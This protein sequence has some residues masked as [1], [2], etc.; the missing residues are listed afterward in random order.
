MIKR[1]TIICSIIGLALLVLSILGMSSL[2]MHAKSLQSER[3]QEFFSVAKKVRFDVKKKLDDFLLTEQTRPYTDYQ[4]YYVP[5]TANRANALVRSPLADKFSNGLANGYFQLNSNNNI[6]NPYAQSINQAAPEVKDYLTNLSKNLLPSLGYGSGLQ[7]SRVEPNN[8][9]LD[10]NNSLVDS[11][12][13]AR[14]TSRSGYQ[15]STKQSESKNASNRSKRYEIGL[16]NEKQAVQ[17]QNLTRDNYESNININNDLVRSQM[18]QQT[19]PQND[20]KRKND[21]DENNRT[22][23]RNQNSQEEFGQYNENNQNIQQRAGNS[24]LMGMGMNALGSMDT[25]QSEVI[26]ARI[27]PFVPMTIAA[28]NGTNGIFSGQVFMLRHVQIENNHYLQGFR[29]DETE[30]LKQVKESADKFMLRGMGFKISKQEIPES[31]YTAVLDF[32]FGELALNLLELQPEWIPNRVS[33]VRNWFFAILSI[34]WLAVII[35]LTMFWKNMYEQVQLSHKKDDFISAVS[36][37]LR[38][39]LTSIRMYT[40]MLEKNWVKTDDKRREYYSNM[41]QESERLTRLVE[42]VLDFSRIQRGKKRYDLTMGN[43]NEC[44]NDT[45]EM[46]K[47]YAERAGF[48]IITEYCNLREFSFDKDAVVQIVIN[49]LDNAFKYA[50]DAENKTII[51]RTIEDKNLAILEVEDRGPG[52]AR[53]EQKKIFEEFYRCGEESTRQTTGTGLGLALV[54]RFAE[55]HNGYAEI[56]NIKPNGALFRVGLAK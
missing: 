43:I 20:N 38:T 21:F 7:V 26:Q 51:V 40:E 30:L 31:A 36:H 2:G 45:V 16:D 32:G 12:N 53:S 25:Y 24:S 55:A 14:Q 19:I 56:T 4:Y 9:N 48:N 50:K 6:I 41:R 28:E 17:T 47:P 27:E 46:M 11:Y 1:F 10:L 54:K 15:N 13:Y 29:L 34:V 44:I 52:V 8:E 18:A 37:E 35:S 5:M 49:L 42:N 23:Q 3:Q 33:Q 22:D 39:P